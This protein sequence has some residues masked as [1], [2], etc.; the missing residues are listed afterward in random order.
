M[1]IIVTTITAHGLT[2]DRQCQT[3]GTYCT[4]Y[5]QQ[6]TTCMCQQ[7]IVCY[8]LILK[9]NMDCNWLILKSNMDCY[10]LILKSNME[11]YWLILISNTWL[12]FGKMNEG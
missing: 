4:I 12:A 3:N 5:Q 8:W 9:S 11:C 2:L 10:W 1:S 6:L 7:C